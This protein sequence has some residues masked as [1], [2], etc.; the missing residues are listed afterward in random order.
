MPIDKKKKFAFVHI[1]KCAGTFVENYF[2]LKRLENF[3]GVDSLI[4]GMMFSPQHYTFSMLNE[5]VD[6]T[7]YYTFSFVRDPYDRVVSE[8]FWNQ[9]K[10]SGKIK[11]S[12]LVEDFVVW[13]DGY[14]SKI[15]SDHKLQQHKFICD[16][17]GKILVNKLGRVENFEQDFREIVSKISGVKCEEKFF[18]DT[19]KTTQYRS[20]YMKGKIVE[21]INEI[22]KKDFELFD[23]DMIT[24]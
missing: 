1:P 3:Y 14:Y 18:K 22:Y 9:N 16:E 21:Q 20:S 6:L 23:Y 12:E 2:N 19:S 15:N 7:D 4:K 5:K 13:F 8:Y 17:N 11:R 10:S 24:P